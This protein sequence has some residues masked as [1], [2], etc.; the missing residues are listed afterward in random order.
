[1][2][3]FPPKSERSVNISTDGNDE[4]L[5]P[6]CGSNYLH[7]TS[8]R[9]MART[10]GEDGP[11]TITSVAGD[12]AATIRSAASS[13]LPGRRDSVEIL[14][15]CE[16]CGEDA[17]EKVLQLLQHKGNTITTWISP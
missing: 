12:G 17:P 10:K 3:N 14:F 11:G 13:E 6:D 7:Q 16:Q 2:F 8:L 4:L 5:C 9:V 1:M 15:W